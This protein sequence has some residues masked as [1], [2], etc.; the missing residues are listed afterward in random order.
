MRDGLDEGLPELDGPQTQRS[1]CLVDRLLFVLLRRVCGTGR[2]KGQR[3]GGVRDWAMR[4][5]QSAS[6][7]L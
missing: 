7:L 5:D 1:E 6:R 2:V 4:Y 3:S